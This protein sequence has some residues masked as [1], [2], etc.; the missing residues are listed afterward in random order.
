[1]FTKEQMIEFGKFY[2][3]YDEMS[4]EKAFEEWEIKQAQ[5]NAQQPHG[6]VCTHFKRDDYPS[7]G[8]YSGWCLSA[9][10]LSPC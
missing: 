6:E 7:T 5:T 9:G 4:V 1:M 8:G 2:Q 10:K 3:Q